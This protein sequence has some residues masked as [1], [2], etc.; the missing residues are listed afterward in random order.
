M[1][2]VTAGADIESR[3]LLALARLAD[4]KLRTEG[5]AWLTDHQI[6]H[7]AAEQGVP[8]HRVEHLVAKLENADRLWEKSNG[9]YEAL[10][11]VVWHEENVDRAEFYRRNAMRREILQRA[12]RASEN[13]EELVFDEGEA[14][15]IEGTWLEVITATRLLAH[16]DLVK[17]DELLGH[18][19]YLEITHRGYDLAGDE[20]D[21]RKSLPT[22]A[23]EDEEAHANVA[24][25]ALAEIITS[26]ERMLASR[27]WEAAL[28]E[29]R[30]GDEQY[31]DEHWVDAVSEYY[32]AVES[33]L[34]YRLEESWI[35]F[36]SGG[37]LR[38]LARL[39]VD[40][41]AI[42]K[43]YQ[44]LFTFLDSVRSPRKH[45]RGSR[46]DEVE[47]GPAEALLMANHA[48]SLLLYLG[49]RP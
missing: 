30:R 11:L 18:S 34:K 12:A 42:P 35:T 21:L 49:H 26:C 37:S 44:A 7:A 36:S 28:T 13:N 15:F 16:Y 17:L 1:T 40:A 6:E 20:A 31:R 41:G 14:Q 38:D 43:N 24:P 32:S 19:F 3:L 45:G 2:A 25:D 46:P 39:A 9:L 29:L 48:R 22:S 23:T 33:G 10:G 27:G 5:V 8:D 4:E 47:V